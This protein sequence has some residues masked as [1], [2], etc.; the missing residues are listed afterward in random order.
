M[1]TILIVIVFLLFILFTPNVVFKIPF[2]NSTK[3]LHTFLFTTAF[4]FLYK[5]LGKN[6]EKMTPETK[7]I[8]DDNESLDRIFQRIVKSV[9]KNKY[10][11]PEECLITNTLYNVSPGSSAFN[12]VTRINEPSTVF[13]DV[14]E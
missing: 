3:I 11:A 6:V 12:D 4:Y 9:L 8:S 2:N 14:A 13:S 7:Y 5:L 10:E 1:N